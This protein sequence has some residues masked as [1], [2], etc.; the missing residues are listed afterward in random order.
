VKETISKSDLISLFDVVEAAAG[1][2]NEMERV[3]VLRRRLGT[4]TAWCDETLDAFN[5]L[6]AKLRV[7]GLAEVKT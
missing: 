6:G 5:D 4:P 7:L 2:Y 1:L 3:L